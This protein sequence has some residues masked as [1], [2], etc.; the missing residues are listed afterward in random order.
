M[1]M[2]V[3]VIATDVGG[4]REL[5]QHE[6]T[7]LLVPPGSPQA[8]ASA[9]QRLLTDKTLAAACAQAA[10]R[11]GQY[12]FSIDAMVGKTEKLYEQLLG[13]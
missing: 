9:I 3:P 6:K 8:M 10:Q 11:N 2:G 7:G 1:S 13:S 4:N 12:N 5:V